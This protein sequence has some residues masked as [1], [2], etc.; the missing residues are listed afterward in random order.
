M[1]IR[2]AK[3]E[4][5]ERFVALG[6]EMHEESNFSNMNWNPEKVGKIISSSLLE[7]PWYYVAVAENED[8]IQGFIGGIC[9]P[10][11]FGDDK[12]ANDLALYITPEYRGSYKTSIK[13]IKAFQKWA[14]EK[15]A[16]RCSIGST[17]GI[18]DERYL[19]FLGRLGF[20]KSGFCATIQLNQL[21]EI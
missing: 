14:E 8:G 10:T 21:K 4:D 6:K 13:L 9:F 20:K 7:N 17:A 2:P 12:Q 15:G 1:N 19:E 5:T 18:V 3:I 16:M 11:F